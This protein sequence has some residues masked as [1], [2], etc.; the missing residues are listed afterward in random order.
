MILHLIRHGQTLANQKHLY[1][2][3]TDLPLTEEG[4]EAIRFLASQGIYPSLEGLAVYTSG[5]LRTQQTLE[6][7][8]GLIP[9]TELPGFQEINFGFFEMKSYEELKNNPDYLAWIEDQSGQVSC[10]EG[11]S[12]KIFT[13][14]VLSAFESLKSKKQP[15]LVI[16]HGGVIVTL[17]QHLFPQEP[18]HFYLWQPRLGEGYSLF[19]SKE[20]ACH[21]L[22]IST[23]QPNYTDKLLLSNF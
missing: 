2:G 1:C 20:N 13:R 21:F 10:P 16:C 12:S 6:A 9:Y 7:I 11:E 19:L 5:L 22:K 3:K 15:S 18:R 17:M 23:E 8:Y 14:R 4:I